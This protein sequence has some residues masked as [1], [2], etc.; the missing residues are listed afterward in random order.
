[1]CKKTEHIFVMPDVYVHISGPQPKM[2][3]GQL[4][5]CGELY[6]VQDIWQEF[7]M[8]V[9]ICPC[10]VC[11]WK[12]D[13]PIESDEDM[14]YVGDTQC[15]DHEWDCAVFSGWLLATERIKQRQ[16]ELIPAGVEPG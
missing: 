4:C 5:E 8:P 11:E 12:N 6:F 14:E 10:D 2:P 3:N 16:P 1:M 13:L 15:N 9:H 7:A